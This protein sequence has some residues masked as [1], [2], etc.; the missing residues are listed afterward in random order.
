MVVVVGIHQW[1]KEQFPTNDV[2]KDIKVESE[3]LS[4]MAYPNP[5]Q[6]EVSF[7]ILSPLAGRALLEVYNTLG[8]KTGCGI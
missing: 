3:K 8:Q 4:V 5:Y 2:P 7:Q 1:K 6:H